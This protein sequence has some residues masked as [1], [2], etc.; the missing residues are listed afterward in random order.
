[1]KQET[2]DLFVG[3]DSRGGSVVE[4]VLVRRL[5]NHSFE[6]LCSPGLVLGL[7]AGD[8]FE[9]MPLGRYRI[10]SRSGNVCV[11]CYP[12]G[13]ID[14][15]ERALAD[16]LR[17]IGGRTDGRSWRQVI[18][19]VPVAVGFPAIEAALQDVLIKIDPA[20]VWNYGNVYEDNE[21]DKP[22]NWWIESGADKP[23]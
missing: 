6:L 1:M 4:E 20:C 12:T 15:F 13:D 23:V 5:E 8:V 14:A 10:V 18:A 11:Q 19:T 16:R 7:A 17:A 22:L 21:E 2:L 9:L 3:L